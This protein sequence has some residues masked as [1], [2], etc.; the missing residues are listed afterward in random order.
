MQVFG[1]NFMY[2][3]KVKVL[4]EQKY[5]QIHQFMDSY[6]CC[7]N[8][9]VAFCFLLQMLKHLNQPIYCWSGCSPNCMLLL[10]T[11]PLDS[12]CYEWSLILLFSVIFCV[13]FF[14]IEQR[15]CALIVYLDKSQCSALHTHRLLCP[16]FFRLYLYFVL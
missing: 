16:L 5:S 10:F 15:Q 12:L 2:S 7:I 14:K 8:V 4:T 11:C 6:S 1:G 9:Y 3:S 13:S